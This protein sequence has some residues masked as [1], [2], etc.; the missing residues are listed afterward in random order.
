MCTIAIIPA[1]SGSKSLPH[2]NIRDFCG[3]PLLVHSIQ[4]ARAAETIDRVFVSTDSE[5]YRQIAL[6]SGAE[7]PFLR[8]E[9]ISQDMSRDVEFVAHFLDYMKQA[10]PETRIGLIVHLRPTCPIRSVGLIDACVRDLR[11]HNDSTCL[12]TVVPYSGKS[13]FK[14]ITRDVTTGAVAPAFS[15]FQNVE[16]P[17][18][19]C[20]QEINVDVFSPNGC[21]DVIRPE[22]VRIY[23]S[24]SG[25][26]MRLYVMDTETIDI[27]VQDDFERAE[28]LKKYVM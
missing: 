7:C 5:E 21:I 23:G 13:I 25:P 22:T 24:V 6:A 8:P 1:R 11:Q 14:M 10:E 19:G 17:Y 20:R 12:R 16:A 2:K 15:S 4:H 9:T 28:K 18:D 27:D 3:Q 26:R